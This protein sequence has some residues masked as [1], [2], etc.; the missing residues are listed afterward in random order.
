MDAKE[1]MSR[2]RENNIVIPAF[3][4]AH[5]P[6]MKPV[7][8]AVVDENSVAMIQVA[9][10]EW[11][12]MGA[13]SIEATAEEYGKCG[14]SAHTL[15][16]LDHVP[17]VDEDYAS[18][19]Y[20]PLIERAIAAGYQS[21]MIDGSRLPL[22]EN[23]AVTEEVVAM[24]HG[25][26]IPCE[27]ELGAVMGHESGPM[28]PYKEIFASKMG[29]TL[30]EE[31]LYFVSRTGVDWLSI[32]A[33]NIHGSIAEATKN[34]KKPE[35]RLDIA[36]IGALYEATKV[37]LVLHGG[38]GIKI[39]HIREAISAGIAKINVGT[40]IRQTYEL[41]LSGSGGNNERACRDVYE[42]IRNIISDLLR[43]SN[44]RTTLALD[45]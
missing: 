18:V 28:P 17:A 9:R 19:E 40:E 37:P 33:G 12:K 2:A 24:A 31:A 35:A 30:L 5:L 10:V 16:H 34:E 11:E 13:G 29:F 25:A 45:A 15:L 27:A 42:R 4:I 8:Q 21:V 3:N 20:K 1:A 26:G 41:S 36:H 44:S 6:M 32:A 7:V 22:E 43:I 14:D 23:I 38:S 39:E